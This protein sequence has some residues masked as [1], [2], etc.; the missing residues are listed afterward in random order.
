MPDAL[1]PFA[2]RLRAGIAARGPM[3]FRDFMAQ[4][5]YDPE[6]GYYGSGKARV[7]RGGDFFTNV[8][9]GPLFG[10]LLARQFSEMWRRMDQPEDFTLVEQGAHHGEAA[11]DVLAG[12]REYD[13][14]CFEAATLWLVEPVP[15]FQ[16]VQ[17]EKLTAFPSAKVRWVQTLDEL[18]NFRGVHYSNE[19]LDAFPVHRVIRR[20]DQWMERVVDFQDGSFVFIDA[21]ISS[22]ALLTHLARLPTVAPDY[23]TEV[24]LASSV[25]LTEVA[26]K[27]HSGFI[28]VIDYGYNRSE[29]YRPERTGGT[30]SAYAAHRREPDPLQRPGEIDLT[31][32]VDFTSVAEIAERVGLQIAGFTD[33]HHFMV[34]LGRLH[35]RDDHALTATGQQELRAFKTL[36]HPGLMGR[37]FHALC[38][39]KGVANPLLAGFQFSPNPRRKLLPD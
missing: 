9:V 7:G 2:E 38:L 21:E 1:T 8:S 22:E 4:A 13:P 19:L 17:Q 5:L 6:H 31:A 39:A 37:S 36:M 20:G 33:Q 12:L 30:L 27:L 16:H 26:T 24:N 29:Y 25:W 34:G 10:R 28:L 23:E 11:A 32:H 14:A 15:A 3:S 18:P 35:F